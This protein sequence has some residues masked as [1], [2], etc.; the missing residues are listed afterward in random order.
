M[1]QRMQSPTTTLPCFTLS[2]HRCHIS[3]F[4]NRCWTCWSPGD[5]T[6]AP[7][8]GVVRSFF[9]QG[10][11][12]ATRAVYQSGWRQYTKFCTE[13]TLSPLP[14][15]EHTLCQFAA[16]LSESVSWGTICSYLSALRFYQI[17]AGLPDPSLASLPRL[18]YLMKGI[19]RSLP[20]HT[21][22]KRLP[23]TPDLL[24]KLHMVWSQD[25]R[26]FDRVMLW[27]A[28]CLGFFGFMR[29]GEFTCPSSQAAAG[30][31]VSDVGIDSHNNPQV[32]IVHLRHSKT[33]QFG[34]G[35][36]LYLGKTG[37]I[38][39]PVAGVLGY[40]AIRPPDPGPLFIH[41]D[42]RPLSRKYLVSQMREALSQ[43]GVNTARFSGH[44]F[45]IGAASTAARAEF[46]DSFIQTLGRWK[47]SAFTTYI[48]TPPEDLIAVA[49]RLVQP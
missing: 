15:T 37:D 28:C 8:S 24:R 34:A 4:H 25:T 2:P 36:H 17:C 47:S 42:G 18:A 38:L 1:L 48:R 23:I 3:P 6:G 32:L 19:H 40:L 41:Q 43:A 10:I 31:T 27:A 30:L 29:A 20:D 46:S 21:R 22:D 14:L 49:T 7:K 44:S 39:C 5:P 16:V 11:S 9:D 26:T 45:R 13:F 35:V 33:D 12:E